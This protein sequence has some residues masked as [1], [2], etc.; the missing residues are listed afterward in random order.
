MHAVF[1]PW[2]TKPAAARKPINADR[3]HQVTP[4]DRN[5]MFFL[6]S[7]FLLSQLPRR[8]YVFSYCAIFSAEDHVSSMLTFKL[9]ATCTTGT[10]HHRIVGMVKDFIATNPQWGDHVPKNCKMK[11]NVQ[12]FLEVLTCPQKWIKIKILMIWLRIYIWRIYIYIWLF[13]YVCYSQFPTYCNGE[14]RLYFSKASV[15]ELLT[16]LLPCS[17]RLNCALAAL[18]APERSRENIAPGGWFLEKKMEMP[19]RTKCS[20]TFSKCNQRV[21][22]PF[23][24]F[25]QNIPKTRLGCW[26]PN[27]WGA[28]HQ[29]FLKIFSFTS[30][31]TNLKCFGPIAKCLNLQHRAL[32][33][34]RGFLVAFQSL[35]CERIQ[36]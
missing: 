15:M 16:D 27:F 20:N 32:G 9:K 5:S 25:Q 26:K 14:I 12:G 34:F 10:D 28:C 19:W 4:Y 31:L 1:K 13:M 7:E 3:W 29:P 21:G 11:A 2:S 22:I 35:K 18:T 36:W 24:A 23:N 33:M 8:C 17:K 6:E 30:S